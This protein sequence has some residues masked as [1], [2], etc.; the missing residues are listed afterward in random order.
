MNELT[1]LDK[2][3]QVGPGPFDKIGIHRI[4]KNICGCQPSTIVLMPGANSD[5]NTSFQKMATFLASRDIDV[6]GIDFRY[7]FVPENIDSNPYCIAA[8]CSFFKDQNTN[9]HLSD[10]DIVVKMAELTSR[11]GKVFVGGWSQGAYFAYRYAINNPN[12]KG[13]IPIDIVY[14]LDPALTDIADKTRIEIA[15]RRSKINSGI[16]YEDVLLAK[17]L[18]YQALSDPDGQS[19]II[20]GLTNKQAALLA[21]TATYQFG[22]NPIPNYRYNQ[23][24]LTGLTYTDFQYAMQQGLKINSFQS[25]F[26]LTEMREQWLDTNIPNI[27]VPVLHIGA[28]FGFGTFGLYTPNKI[29]EFNPDVDTRIIPEYGHTDLMYSNTGKSDVWMTIYEWIRRYTHNQ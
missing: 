29:H 16:F 20:P 24:D 8:D 23:G 12:L 19:T 1:T 15:M 26:P 5:F 21:A 7:S 18:G 25:I 3:I 17:Y 9:L 2:T 13:I 4:T 14:N 22:I 11:N 28:E 27:T 10:L 6:W